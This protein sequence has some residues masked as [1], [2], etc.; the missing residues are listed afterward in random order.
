M[1]TG[2]E[3]KP[4]GWAALLMLVGAAVYFVFFHNKQIRVTDTTK[5]KAYVDNG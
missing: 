5:G 4:L 1:K 3:I 2:W